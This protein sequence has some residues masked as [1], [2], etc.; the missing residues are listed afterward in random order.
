MRLSDFAQRAL[1]AAAQE[2]VRAR[3]V[4]GY[5]AL[6]LR[7]QLSECRSLVA[8]GVLTAGRASPSTSRSTGSGRLA[9]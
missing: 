8:H 7:D 4:G 6:G 2:R 5:V 3:E 1:D 9:W